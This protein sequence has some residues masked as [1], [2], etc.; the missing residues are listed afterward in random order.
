[1]HSLSPTTLSDRLKA[2]ATR[3]SELC[4]ANAP[5]LMLETERLILQ[6]TLME[7]PVDSE[8]QLLLLAEEQEVQAELRQHLQNTGYFQK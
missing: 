4:R 1:M 6:R 7:F 3:L 2:S 8:C 5:A